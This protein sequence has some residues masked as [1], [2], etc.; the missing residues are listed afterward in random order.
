MRRVTNILL[1]AKEK[2]VYLS[3]LSNLNFILV[4]FMGV[5]AQKNKQHV[6]CEP[7]L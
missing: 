3:I 4:T 5:S 7:K 1:K 6:I 2:N